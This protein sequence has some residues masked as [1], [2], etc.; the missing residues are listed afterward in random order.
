MV[1]SILTEAVVVVGPAPR[2][3]EAMELIESAPLDAALLDINLNGEMTWDVADILHD[4]GIPFVFSTGYDGATVLP[5]RFAHQKVIRKPFTQK[6]I[7]Q[8]LRRLL[9]PSQ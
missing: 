2:V 7:E 9:E 3:K 5:E 8:G 1:V 4:R 6:D